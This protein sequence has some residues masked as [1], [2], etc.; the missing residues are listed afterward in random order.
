MAHR[1]EAVEGQ[2]AAL[3]QARD[4]AV[5]SARSCEEQAR[6][7]GAARYQAASRAAGAEQREQQARQEA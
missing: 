1:A 4:A 3:Q 2:L 6:Q 5:A 7:A